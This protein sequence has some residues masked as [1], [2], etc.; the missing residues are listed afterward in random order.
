VRI[1][2][3]GLAV[4]VLTLASHAN[5][6][7]ALQW[8]GFALLRASNGVDTPA[9]REKDLSAQLHLGVDWSPSP[10]LAAHVH[11]LARS[12]D[13]NARR[14]HFGVVEA[15]LEARNQHVRVRGGA[16]FLPSSR[17][18]VDALWEP[19]YT[20]TPSALNS[21]L[22][23]EFR[24]IGI[25]A[26]YT[27]SGLTAGATI[28]RGNDTL[29]GIPVE[30]GWSMRD[31]WITLGEWIPVDPDYYTSAS[32]ENDHRVGWS[33][34]GVWNGANA[35]VQLTHIDNRGDGLPYGRL[36]NWGTRFD[37]VSGEYSTGDW[38][39]A[40]ESGWGPT[41]LIVQGTKYTTDIR[42][43][44]ALASRRF[45]RFRAT[46][47]ADDF[48]AVTHERALT[49]AFLWTPPGHLRPGFEVSTSGGEERVIVELRYS[50]AGH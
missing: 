35:L 19:A 28:F 40:A 4:L 17:E 25:D 18:N 45:P 33:A 23:E 38:T 29:G 49:F 7:D 37:I 43:S 11:L 42:A 9:L 41:F 14:G 10:F 5:A 34:R 16:F 21:W 3:A 22:G 48:K 46:L 6:D 30:R 8:S 2:S 32:A 24:P 26:S 50:F 13:A 20:I 36:F 31:H 44:Y 1:A 39:F 15:Y 47:R 27:R 12:D